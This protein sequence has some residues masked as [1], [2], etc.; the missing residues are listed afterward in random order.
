MMSS[1]FVKGGRED[2][3][4]AIVSTKCGKYRRGILFNLTGLMVNR[5]LTSFS[6]WRK[7]RKLARIVFLSFTKASA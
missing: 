2:L 1:S 6:D 7:G 5:C 4:C 3:F